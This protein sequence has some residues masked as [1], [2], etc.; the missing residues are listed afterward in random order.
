MVLG[1]IAAAL[2][3]AFLFALAEA[4]ILMLILGALH[5]SFPGVPA[6]GFWPTFPVLL[7]LN[8]IGSAFR[9]RE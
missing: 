2:A 1:V 6:L 4:W 8:I 7:L 9:K 5:T 3:L